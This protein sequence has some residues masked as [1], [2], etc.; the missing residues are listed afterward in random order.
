YYEDKNGNYPAEEFILSLEPKMRAKVAHTLLLLEQEGNN[1]RE[2]YSKYL[3]DGIFELRVKSGSNISRVFYFFIINKTIV[4]TNG[5]IKKTNKTPKNE[6][7]KAK[8]YRS[9]FLSRNKEG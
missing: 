7:T 4:L 6:L 2:P 1:L 8:N 5:F 9:D 3:E